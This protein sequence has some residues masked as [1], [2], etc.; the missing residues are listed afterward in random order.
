MCEVESVIQRTTTSRSTWL[1]RSSHHSER[2]PYDLD[3]DD[4]SSPDAGGPGEQGRPPGLPWPGYAPP[5]PRRPSPW[6]TAGLAT[7]VSFATSA[8]V[9]SVVGLLVL[10]L[11]GLLLLDV[12]AET[13]PDPSD[14]V[15]EVLLPLG[16]LTLGAAVAAGVVALVACALFLRSQGALRPWAVSTTAHVASLLAGGLLGASASVAPLVLAPVL[17]LLTLA[18]PTVTVLLVTGVLLTRTGIEPRPPRGF[19]QPTSGQPTPGQPTP[20]QP[21]FRQPG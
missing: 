10:L 11:G 13:T 5:P 17:W 3:V 12:L 6:G 7:L 15:G 21:T 1:T 14:G 9:G 16:L 18:A 20:G 4:A 19:P 2:P 8:L